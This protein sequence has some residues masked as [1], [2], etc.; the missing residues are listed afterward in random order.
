MADYNMMEMMI[1][2]ASR[3]LENG[4]T[5][6]VGTGAPCAAAMLAQKMASPELIIMFEAGGISPELPEMPISVGDSR[7]FHK[8][9]MAG[10]MGDIMESCS[11]GFVDYTFLG[12]AQ[13]DMYGNLN[14]TVIGD[15]ANPKVRL[16]GSGGANDFASF[17]WRMMVMTP[18]DARRFVEKV[19]FMTTPGWLEGGDS[20]AE[21]GLPLD[22]GP[23]K[24]ITNMAVMDFEPVSKRMR[25]IS[26]NPGYSLQDIQDNCG[27]ELLKAD[28]IVETQAPTEEE[29]RILREE[30]DPYGYVIGR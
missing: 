13:I 11:R 22:A 29:L 12:G 15:H 4:A 17:C 16:P 30:V 5:V 28:K 8:A 7:T 21:S 2:V 1:S 18:Q 26:V 23:Y 14:S 25:I 10:S 27:F 19:D 9:L 6:G 20:R 24:I 3:E